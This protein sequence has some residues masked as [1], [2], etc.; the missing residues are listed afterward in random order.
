MQHIL[1][2]L[3]FLL[4]LSFAG[5][6]TAQSTLTSV[7][8]SP[9]GALDCDNLIVNVTGT[10]PCANGTL[11]GTSSSI[12]GTTIFIDIDVFQ[13]LICLP[14]IFP[15][16]PINENVGMVPAGSY[17]ITARY[18]ENG[19]L[20]ATLS[21]PVTI[22]TCCAVNPGI[23]QTLSGCP[24]D[25]LTFFAADTSLMSY[26][27]ELDN[28]VVGTDTLVGI[29]FPTAG[30][31]T[32]S[33]TASDGSCTNMSTETVTIGLP[34]PAFSQVTNES[35][36]GTMDGSIDLQ[37]TGTAPPYTYLWSN[38][39]T[40][41][42]ISQLVAGTYVVT[43]SDVNGCSVVDSVTLTSGVA[44]TADFSTSDFSKLCPGDSASFVNASTGATTYNWT[45]NGQAFASSNDTGYTFTDTGSF[46]VMLVAS[47][48][49]CD[50][51]TS[52]SFTVAQP[53][54]TANTTDETC[55]GSADGAID[56]TVS[57]GIMPYTY[58]WSNGATTADIQSLTGGDYIIAVSDSLG[59]TTTDTIEVSTGPGVEAVF[60]TN[61]NLSICPEVAIDFTNTS[62]MGTTVEW[63]S[64]G[65]SFAQSMN[66]SYV[67]PDSGV[68]EI[69]LVVVDGLCS[70]TM[71]MNFTINEA[72]ALSEQLSDETCPGSEDGSIDLNLTGGAGPF[73]FTWSNGAQ[74]E[75]IQGLEPDTYD[76]LVSFG[77]G[78]E[79]R[80]T[81]EVETL[82]GVT[83]A[84]SQI[85]VGT[86]VNFTDLSDTT[87]TSWMWDFGDGT[88][89]STDQNPFYAFPFSGVYEVCLAIMDTYGCTDTLCESVSF[90][91]GL[92]Q[93]PMLPI[94]VYP[95]PVRTTLRLDLSSISGHAAR[96]QL[97]DLS[98]KIVFNR[99]GTVVSDEEID[100]TQLATG[101][102]T[103]MISCPEGYF[104]TKIHKE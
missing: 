65:V 30:T 12:V 51:T 84:F 3:T 79:A 82:G 71:R 16:P 86:G 6:L 92:D 77:P 62:T 39:S 23:S 43:V 1:R 95:N 91:V 81:F 58:S 102:Y 41:E 101:L 70:D 22:G 13:P 38:G 32:L 36:P 25:S 49:T 68:V 94:E 97:Y 64:D 19:V 74:T 40:T 54:L 80:D 88:G 93:M 15:L 103:L 87:T 66:A 90:T 7:T 28:V 69:S 67:F 27:W 37:V 17:T 61:S 59:C 104:E 4:I 35:C 56:L 9:A 60:T 24:G 45:V 11:Q 29:N 10:L 83:A 78:C 55:G 48:A 72:P 52:L 44:V 75:D 57:S 33:L 20:G 31:Y 14:A 98:G 47:N 63:F 53:V 2:I 42:D 89:T 8:S 18:F 85:S 99:E 34:A 26:S 73:T 96:I 100:M 50:D 76:V 21:T 46:E 5:I